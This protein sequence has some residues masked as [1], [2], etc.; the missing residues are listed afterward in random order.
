MSKITTVILAAGNSTRFKSKKSKLTQDLAGLPIVS[1]VYN[2]AKNI[3]GK[4]VI[5]VC[6][7]KNINE[8]KLLLPE[9][10]F[11]LQ[12]NQNGTADAIN[13][14]KFLIKNRTLLV[15]FGDV[16]LL[17]NNTLKKLIKNFKKNNNLASM[18]AFKTLNPYGYGR[19]KTNGNNIISVVEEIFASKEEKEIKICNSGVML[20]N[21]NKFFNNLKLIKFNSIKK[22]KFLPDIFN[23]Y[24]KKQIPFSFIISSEN[25][26]L[27]VNTINDLMIAEKM[28]QNNLVN[29]FKRNGV[30]I[31]KPDS[32]FFSYDTKIAKDVIIE[33]NVIIKN[34]VIIK[35]GTVIKSYSYL[36]GAQIDEE[37]K[38]GPFARIRPK[39]VI[40]KKSK[41]GN[42][43]EIKN[44][45]IGENTSISH[46][47]YIGD[48]I[49]GKKVNIGA[50]TITCNFDGKLKHK[51]I[52]KD[53]A[54]VGSNCSL[55]APLIINKNAKIGAGSVINQNI[56]SNNLAIE[57]SKLK[58]I[59]KK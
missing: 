36:E 8:L 37:C 15:L 12:K 46:L 24:S 5:I 25:E 32:S 2:I 49:L 30:F 59:I 28:F 43:V 42:Y 10:K 33:Q 1:H 50:G 19:V 54:F 41:I 45:K 13:S 26:M 22:E 56:P 6:N 9:C 21:T 55:V 47:S 11:V 16:P 29:R 40:N 34:K 31:Y 17:S 39:T 35:S 14:A 23:I 27:G 4:D 3:S 48:S 7:N 53:G 51:T 38:I 57:R 52:I 18:I 20:V 44:S 58:I